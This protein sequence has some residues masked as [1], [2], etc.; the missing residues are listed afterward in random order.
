VLRAAI[1]DVGGVILKPL[2]TEAMRAWEALLGLPRDTIERTIYGGPAGQ[3]AMLG[4]ISDDT[5]WEWVQQHFSLTSEE[6]DGLRLAVQECYVPDPEVMELVRDLRALCRTAIISNAPRALRSALQ[7]IYRISDHFDLIVCSAE[8]GIA[9]PDPAIY[10][11]A[12]AR[13]DLPPESAVLL[14]DRR[15]NIASARA[16]GLHGIL[17][18]E[19]TNLRDELRRLGVPGVRA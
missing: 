12:L 11:C 9:K 15:D 3:R 10:A 14:D 7:D 6:R 13:L 17:V 5:H 2:H 19:G 8:E 18:E 1:F 16:A 4:E